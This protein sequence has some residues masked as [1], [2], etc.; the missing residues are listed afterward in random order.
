MFLSRFFRF[1][2][3]SSRHRFLNNF[4]HH[5]ELRLNNWNKNRR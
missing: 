4:S 1:D 2:G 5:D 3:G